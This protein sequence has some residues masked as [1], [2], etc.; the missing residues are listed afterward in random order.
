VYLPGEYKIDRKLTLLTSGLPPVD[1]YQEYAV[2]SKFSILTIYL[3]YTHYICIYLGTIKYLFSR[4]LGKVCLLA[5]SSITGSH[6][7]LTI[8][9]GTH[10]VWMSTS[11]KNYSAPPPTHPYKLSLRGTGQQQW[12]SWTAGFFWAETGHLASL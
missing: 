6:H 11:P 5:T 12:Y 2:I 3:Y 7:F 8:R 10:C 9:E 1:K 4:R